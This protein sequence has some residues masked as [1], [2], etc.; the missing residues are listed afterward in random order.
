MDDC[1]NE[2]ECEDIDT[3]DSARD[4]PKHSVKSQ[5]SNGNV[6]INDRPDWPDRSATNRHNFESR[7]PVIVLGVT[8]L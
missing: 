7:A 8:T 6:A 2:R 4:S 5:S 1:V 3:K